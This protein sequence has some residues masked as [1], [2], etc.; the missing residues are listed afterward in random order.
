MARCPTC[1]AEMPPGEADCPRCMTRMDPVP[2]ADQP[3]V[4]GSG[5][6]PESAPTAAPAAGARPAAGLKRIEHFQIQRELGAGGMGTVYLARDERMKRDVA[7]KVMSGHQSSDKAGRRFEQEAWIAGRLDHPGIVKV[8]ERGQWEELSYFAMEL[9]DGGSLAD[10]IESMRRAGRNEA[11]GLEFGTSQYIHWA[12]R[13]AIEAARA[14]DFAHRQGIVHRDVKPVNLLLSRT[15]GAV[16]LADFGIAMD[17][18]ATRM[19]TAGTVLG[20]VLYMAPEQIRGDTQKI[21]AR[22]DVYALGVTLFESITLEMP[23]VGVTQQLY[24]SQVLTTE[25]RRAR[26][27]NGRVSRDLDTVLRKAMEKAPADRY[28]TAAAFAD[29]LENVLHLRPIAARPVG[30][31]RRTAKWIRRRPVHAALVATLV[32]GAP[33]AGYIGARALRERAAARRLLIAD[34]LDEARWLGQRAEYGA[35]LKRAEALLAMEPDN[36]MAVRHRAMARFRLAEAAGE[37]TAGQAL[38]TQALGDADTVIDAAPKAAWPHTLKAW[39]LT[40]MGR[41]DDAAAEAA[42]AAALR[43]DPPSDEDVGEEARLATAR[44]DHRL[45]VD[46]HSELIRRNPDSARAVMA[47]ALA[48]ENLGEPDNALVD[49]RVAVGLD[50]DY[51]LAMI[52]IAQLSAR[53]GRLDDAEAHLERALAVDPENPFAL[54][55]QGMILVRQGQEAKEAGEVEEARQFFARAERATRAAL[56]RSD[57]LLWAELNLATA[58]SE[59]AKVSGD[60]DPNLMAQAI[61]LFQQVLENYASVPAAGQPRDVYVAAQSNLCDAQIAMRRLQEALSTCSR[62]T[63]TF[64]DDPV[65]FYNL[66]GAHALMG[67]K[68][69]ALDALAKDVELGDTDWEY[70]VADPWFESLRGDPRFEAIVAAMKGKSGTP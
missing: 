10:V 31:A 41:A 40:Q 7:L 61:A 20:T 67:N 22:T 30:R 18:E 44:A 34:S 49:Y 19:T 45:A 23:Y 5:D 69:K 9:V 62:I 60:A 68:E 51:D 24:M 11:L 39:M 53:S 50:P 37:T 70:L 14:L 52:S 1:A 54:E 25:T 43:S 65:G 26:K 13:T 48:Y 3:T 47:R 33:A 36:V 4:I 64:P 63:E 59:R 15:L 35:M 32:V 46:L 55:T 66:A 42:R 21:D 6:S 16:K 56:E 29:D 17:I 8:Y 58:I 12:L 28:Q 2:L 27:L 57:A 38:R